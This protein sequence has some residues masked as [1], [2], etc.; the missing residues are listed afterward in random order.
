MD[1]AFVTI[2]SS[3]IFF[4][5]EFYIFQSVKV[6]FSPLPAKWKKRIYFIYWTSSCFM[7]ISY[8]AFRYAIPSLLPSSYRSPIIVI[9]FVN[10]FSKSF[11]LLFL[12]LDDL[13]RMIKWILDKTGL[14][15]RAVK[16]GSDD[17]Q[18]KGITRS[19]FL[20]RAVI[21]STI[22]P[23]ATMAYGI[24]S[25][26]HDYKIRRI[27]LPLKNLPDAFNGI[28]IA[29]LSDIHAGSFFNKTAVSGG[30]DMVMNEKPDIVFFT[31][32]I[33][34]ERSTELRGYTDIFSKIKAPLGV[35]ATLGN[36]DYGDYHR[37]PSAQAKQQNLLL[38]ETAFKEMGWDLLKNEHRYIQLS[39]DKIAIIGVENWGA[40]RFSKYG[41]LE[42]AQ[43]GVKDSPVKIL[44]SHDPSHWDA[45]IRPEYADI[46][47]TFSGHTHGFQFGIET[48]NFQWSP[49]QYIYKQWAGLYQEG[50]QF[51]YVNRGFGYVGYPGRIGI[52]PE[53]TIMELVKA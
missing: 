1:K 13:V 26:A 51:L 32:D 38:L 17:K 50:Q 11:G 43:R 18:K 10:Y 9:L 20:S 39:Q 33:V 19:Q 42:T 30:V 25:G 24:I 22:V 45:Q 21:V 14:M 3:I 52:L 49:S 12:L 27:R 2:V 4:L 41:D 5:I 36:H 40:G 7:I 44:L 37:W 23:A 15:V 35:Y 46:D 31:G 8:L 34:N 16:K 48:P 53:I 28:K 29:Q 6:V 47:L